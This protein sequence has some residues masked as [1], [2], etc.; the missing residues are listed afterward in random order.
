MIMYDVG[1]FFNCY[2]IPCVVYPAVIRCLVS[3]VIL[4]AFYFCVCVFCEAFVTL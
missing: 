4:D 2:H 3:D 1:N